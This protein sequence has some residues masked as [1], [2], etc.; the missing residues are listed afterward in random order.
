M[1]KGAGSVCVSGEMP[2]IVMV[3]GKVCKCWCQCLGIVSERENGNKGLV[4]LELY[5]SVRVRLNERDLGERLH[6]GDCA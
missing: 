4:S 3:C 2:L 1:S 5:S 6:Q